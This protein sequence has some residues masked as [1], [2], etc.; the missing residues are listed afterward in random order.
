VTAALD[1]VVRPDIDIEVYFHELSPTAGFD[2]LVPLA[3]LP[4][5]RRIHY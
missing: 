5:V 1:V 2:V 3:E 4:H